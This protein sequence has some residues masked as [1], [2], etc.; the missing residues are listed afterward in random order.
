[1]FVK[2]ETI[3]YKNNIFYDNID[4]IMEDIANDILDFEIIKSIDG[5]SPREALADYLSDLVKNS[6]SYAFR[7]KSF[8]FLLL[9]A[10]KVL[11]VTNPDLPEYNF[12]Y[13]FVG[14]TLAEISTLTN[15]SRRAFLM[16][17]S[18]LPYIRVDKIENF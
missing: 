5:K 11:G 12:T 4:E 13:Y 14:N 1:M 18:L 2:V 16:I 15:E 6:F 9:D 17:S 3:K 10:I 8:M 7:N